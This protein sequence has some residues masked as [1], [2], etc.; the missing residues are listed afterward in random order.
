M[1]GM[2]LSVLLPLLGPVA[3][4]MA[5]PSFPA[6]VAAALADSPAPPLLATTPV[7]LRALVESG[8]A[9]PP[10]AGI[11]SATAPLP[12]ELAATA[13]ARFGCEVR[14]VFGST[15][16]CVFARRSEERRVGTEGRARSA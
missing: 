13:E 5:R 12:R 16:T 3:V 11:V 8:L 7:H 14:E 9:L 6:E 10:L 4:H 15:E 2:E 1:Y